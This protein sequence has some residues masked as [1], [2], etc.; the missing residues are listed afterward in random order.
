MKNHVLV[1]SFLI[2]LG[3][4]KKKF[5]SGI[6]QD[7]LLSQDTVVID[8]N[9]NIINLKFGL[10]DP[11]LSSDGKYLYHYTQGEAKFDIIN[12]EDLVREETLQFEKEGPNGMPA[13]LFGYTLTSADQLL[14]WSFSRNAVFDR[15]GRKVK[16]LDLTKI[17]KELDGHQSSPIRLM[18]HPSDPNKIFALY[19]KHPDNQFFMMKFDLEN[20]TYEIISLPESEKLIDYQMTIVRDGRP[21]GGFGEVPMAT[22]IHDK[23]LVTNG[24][25]NE[26]NVYDISLDSLYLISWDSGLTGNQNEYKLPKTVEVEQASEHRRKYRESINFSV[27]KWDPVTQRYI[28]LSYKTKFGENLNEFGEAEETGAEVFLT[29]LDKDLNIV[30]ETFLDHYQK[31]PE[32]HFFYDNKIWLYENIDDELGFVR[33][34]VD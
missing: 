15:G 18:E 12:L 8:P 22:I 30:K 31:N 26:S 14:V 32:S 1:L 4:A 23:I 7:F 29:V 24:A 16:E 9:G 5:N 27:P 25:Y 6:D 2:L 13:F 28:R 11:V 33:I 20:E 19:V 34:T 21:A 3:C 17:A 10:T